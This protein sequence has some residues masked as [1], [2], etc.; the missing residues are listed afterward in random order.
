M[1]FRRRNRVL[2]AKNAKVARDV[3]PLSAFKDKARGEVKRYEI[4]GELWKSVK[5]LL[6]LAGVLTLFYFLRECYL[7]W[8]IFQ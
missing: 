4:R 7:A 5:K 8:N 1:F 3:D 2:F 6:W